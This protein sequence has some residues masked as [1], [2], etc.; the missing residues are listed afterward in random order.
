MPSSLLGR[1]LPH[2][3]QEDLHLPGRL[4]CVELAEDQAYI[5][6]PCLEEGLPGSVA[7]EGWGRERG[8]FPALISCRAETPWFSSLLPTI[9]CR[10][11]VGQSFALCGSPN[12]HL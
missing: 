3:L 9:S 10:P 1:P 2:P 4:S 7:L 6:M 8:S 12:S 11:D 5:Y